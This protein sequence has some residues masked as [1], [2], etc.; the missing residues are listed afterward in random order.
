MVSCIELELLVL[1]HEIDSVSD[2][3]IGK[4]EKFNTLEEK[5]TAAMDMSRQ[6]V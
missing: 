2:F 5:N 6:L 3:Y 1:I 4:N